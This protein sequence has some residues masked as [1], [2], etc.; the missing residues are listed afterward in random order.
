MLR[1]LPAQKGVRKE[2]IAD[3]LSVSTAVNN[4]Q[5]DEDMQWLLMTKA[6]ACS[7]GRPASCMAGTL[8]KAATALTI[9]KAR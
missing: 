1:A 7:S 2:F 3:Q 6:A 4:H 9:L 5:Q 8:S